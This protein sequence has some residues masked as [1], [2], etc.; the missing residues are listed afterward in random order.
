MAI[1]RIAAVGVVS[2]ALSSANGQEP[3][4]LAEAESVPLE[5]ASALIAAG[6]LGGEPQILV[7]SMPEWASNRLV[8]PTGGRLV[9]SAFLGTTVV[10]V[11]SVSGAPDSAVANLKT[12]FL[13][14][15]WKN[16]PP[17]PIYGG[18]GFRPSPTPAQSTGLPSRITLCGDQQMLLVTG[19]RRR[20]GG[21]EITYRLYAT[22]GNNQCNPPQMPAQ[23]YRTPFPILYNP[24]TAV[25]GYMGN[26]C[27]S[28]S[29]GSN[30]TGTILRS[31]MTAEAL[32]DHY[33]RQIVD[34]GWTASGGQIAGRT[35]TKKDSTGAPI[36]MT[37]TISPMGKDGG[38]QRLDLQ[39]RSFPKP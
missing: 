23:T 3:R 14:R 6:P 38:C 37:L 18:G 29:S 30:G 17:A 27:Q 35:W 15:G 26:V 39:V 7:G 8:V 24:P 2:V 12:E 22:S 1:A 13:Q 11:I 5:L 21:S 25:E 9:G 4:R 10:A 31:S 16:P 20:L 28:N 32:L 36:E 34:S 19:A 33:A